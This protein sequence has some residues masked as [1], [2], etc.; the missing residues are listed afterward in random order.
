MHEYLSILNVI[1]KKNLL[2]YTVIT[3]FKKIIE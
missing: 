1:K 3:G 2:Y